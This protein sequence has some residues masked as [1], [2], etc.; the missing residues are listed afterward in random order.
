MP[1]NRDLEEYEQFQARNNSFKSFFSR[2]SPEALIGLFGL[3]II[4]FYGISKTNVNPYVIFGSIILLVGFIIFRMNRATAET[5]IPLPT[6][7]LLAV[8]VVE[9]SVGF[10]YE[11]GTIVQPGQ[12]AR[13]VEEGEYG[14]PY[15]AWKWEVGVIIIFPS[16]LQKEV[17]VTMNPFTG[18]CKAITPAASGFTG[19]EPANRDRKIII[20]T[21]EFMIK[22]KEMKK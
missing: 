9:R 3:I 16:G 18:F 14:T 19:L 8:S 12:Y 4:G 13:M 7:R 17:R 1:S 15:H 5:E 6:I 2:T 20:P 10:V 21:N 22:D 11:K